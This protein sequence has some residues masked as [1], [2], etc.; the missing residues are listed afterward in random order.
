M[1][2]HIRK[3]LAEVLILSSLDYCNVLYNALPTY[4]IKCCRVQN[5]AA[6]TCFVQDRFANTKSVLDMKWLRVKERIDLSIAKYT[7]KSLH[8]DNWP[9]YL[10]VQ[11][12]SRK[13]F[14]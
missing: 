6:C 12:A 4:L 8:F 7:L 2:Y 3:E 13:G 11:K 5:A 1:P 10:S 9:F 14:A